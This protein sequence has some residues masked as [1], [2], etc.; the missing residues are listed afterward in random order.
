VPVT[1]A[2][3]LERLLKQN[4]VPYEKHIYKDQAHTFR[5]LAQL[6][7]MRRVVGFFR[8]YLARAA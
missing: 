7:A 8:K 6:D 1:E 3:E 2:E 4:N 5:G